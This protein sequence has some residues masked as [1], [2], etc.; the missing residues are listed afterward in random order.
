MSKL[1]EFKESNKITHLEVSFPLPKIK[2][3]DVQRLDLIDFMLGKPIAQI[4]F[5][6]FL[7]D[8]K[9]RSHE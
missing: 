1:H 5:E 2:K 9:R 7:Y 6:E 8:Y 3:A 4:E